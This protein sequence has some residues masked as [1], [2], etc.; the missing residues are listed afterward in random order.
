MKILIA[1]ALLD[2]EYDEMKEK[3][4]SHNSL[5]WIFLVLNV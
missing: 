4:K 5:K 3:V 2:S 1:K